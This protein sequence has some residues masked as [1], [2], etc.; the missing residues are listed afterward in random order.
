[1]LQLLVVKGNGTDVVI[2][3]KGAGKFLE[4]LAETPGGSLL[5]VLDGVARTYSFSRDTSFANKH[6]ILAQLRTNQY[7]IRGGVQ[8]ICDALTDAYLKVEWSGKTPTLWLANYQYRLFKLLASHPVELE[9]SPYLG[10]FGV[11]DIGASTLATLKPVV[12]G[13]TVV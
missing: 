3:S 4:V 12:Q 9:V 13:F 10:R 2:R 11:T 1:M 6:E 5:F 7:H 8:F